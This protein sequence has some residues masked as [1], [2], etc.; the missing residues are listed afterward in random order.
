ME[1]GGGV[2]DDEDGDEEEDEE[3]DGNDDDVAPDPDD[4]V[5]A[6]AEACADSIYL[7]GAGEKYACLERM[8]RSH[9]LS[10]IT[11]TTSS[12]ITPT[13]SATT[14]AAAATAMASA[15]RKKNA[16][17]APLRLRTHG[18]ER[19]SHFLAS[20]GHWEVVM[21]RNLRTGPRHQSIHSLT[22]LPRISP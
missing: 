10:A 2:D 18:M 15:K 17:T 3:E 20:A 21:P 19:G 11:T 4:R 5:A 6:M 1:A 13:T 22:V 14:T 9:A 8:M 12:A 16:R 7:Q